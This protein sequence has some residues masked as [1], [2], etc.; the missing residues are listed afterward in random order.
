MD[1]LYTISHTSSLQ[2]N[3]SLCLLVWKDFLN[4]NQSETRIAHD[5]H[6]FVQLGWNEEI[7]RGLSNYPLFGQT[8]SEKNFRNLP[9]RNKNCL[10]RQC[11]LTNW[12]KMSNLYRGPSID[13]SYQV[14][15]H[16]AKQFQKRKF[17]DCIFEMLINGMVW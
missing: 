13:A 15:V 7:L 6:V 4:F 5:D 3:N 9:T 10:W 2:R 8:V 11:L 17:L 12:G 16:L 1:I 14:S